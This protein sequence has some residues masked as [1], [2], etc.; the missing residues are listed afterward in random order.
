M[1]AEPKKLRLFVA[2]ELPV[3]V[4]QA[5]D[6][7][8]EPLRGLEGFRWTPIENLHLTLAFLGWVAPD[9]GVLDDMHRRLAGAAADLVPIEAS[10]GGAGG[11]PER[12]KVRVVWV[13]FDDPDGHLAGLAH[14]VR[15]SLGD[16]FPPDERPFRAHITVARAT[17]P[18]RMAIPATDATGP[19]FPVDAITLFRSRLGGAHARYEALATWPLG[20]QRA[21]IP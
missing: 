3:D 9:P 12:G 2:V 19:S 18:V 15:D 8:I 20:A 11:F 7:L 13:G 6:E 5:I 21:R 1:N 16:R 10:I 17:R 4:R 14:A